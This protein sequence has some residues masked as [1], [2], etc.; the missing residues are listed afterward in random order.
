MEE[1]EKIFGA[2]PWDKLLPA[3]PLI[4]WDEVVSSPTIDWEEVERKAGFRS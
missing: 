4:D 1:G 3:R 2:I